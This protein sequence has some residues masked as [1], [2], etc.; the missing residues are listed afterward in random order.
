VLVGL[1][2]VGRLGF[3]G[4]DVPDGLE[5]SSVVV[6]VDPLER[7]PLDIFPAMPG[8]SSVDDLGLIQAVDGLGERVVVAVA[9]AADEGLKTGLGEAFRV[10]KGYVLGEP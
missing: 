4:G 5:D 9:D 6:P 7:G 1:Q 2:I 10:S 8:S 3:S